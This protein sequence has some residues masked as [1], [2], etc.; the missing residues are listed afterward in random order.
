MSLS[1]RHMLAVG[2][3]GVAIAA[4]PKSLAQQSVTPSPSTNS[5]GSFSDKVVL[6]T[7]ATS[8]IGKTTAEAFAKQ[9]AKVFFCGRR[10]NLGKQV[11]QGIRAMGGEA[12]YMQA[13]VRQAAEVKAFVEACAAKY[14]RL[15]IAF[16]NAS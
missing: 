9:G 2:A 3:T 11:E 1:R 12:T 14:G 4:A 16:N 15:D 13:D 7:G 5:Q 8:G 6:I 10:E